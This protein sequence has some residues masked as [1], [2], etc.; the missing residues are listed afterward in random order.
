MLMKISEILKIVE[1][2]TL[3]IIAQILLA[4]FHQP[5]MDFFFFTLCPNY[6]VLENLFCKSI[7]EFMTHE[8]TS[9]NFVHVQKAFIFLTQI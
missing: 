8:H 5:D 3:R 4:L 7:I 1:S 6:N 9:V 2:W